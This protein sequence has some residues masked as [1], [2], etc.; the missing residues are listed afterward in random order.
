MTPLIVE[1][2]KRWR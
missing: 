1:L 2:C